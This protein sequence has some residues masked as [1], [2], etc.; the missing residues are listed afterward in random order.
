MMS[1]HGTET[2][3]FVTVAH[4]VNYYT[5]LVLAAMVN[6]ASSFA[7]VVVECKQQNFVLQKQKHTQTCHQLLM[8]GDAP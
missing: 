8:A 7:F 4:A 6:L 5:T 1:K 2:R 3:N